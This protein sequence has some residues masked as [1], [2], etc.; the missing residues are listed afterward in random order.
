M[1]SFLNKV[2]YDYLQR[3]RSYGFLIALCASLAIAYSFVPEPNASYS[4]IRIGEFIGS[5]NSAWF[6]YVTAIMTSLFLSLIGFYLVNSGIKTD[7]TTR[8][9]QIMAATRVKNLNYLLAKTMSNFLVLLTITAVV[10]LMGILL[11][12][13]YR[14]SGFSFQIGHFIRPYLFITLPALFFV[15]ALAVC[16]EILLGRFTTVQNV[17]FFFLFCSLAI[18]TPKTDSRF[19]LDV[20]GSKI[21]TDQMETQVKALTGVSEEKGLTIGYVLGNLTKSKKFEFNGID[22][23]DTFV[24]SRL[25]WM[26]FGLL[27]VFACTPFFHRFDFRTPY[28]AT[29][30]KKTLVAQTIVQDIPLLDLPIGKTDYGILA[31]IKTELLLLW[32]SGKKWMWVI[33]FIGMGLLAFLPLNVAHKTVLPILWFLQVGRF[34]DL[35][36]KDLAHR[37]HYLSFSSHRP[38]RRLLLSQVLAASLGMLV[39]AMPM[40]VRYLI[41]GNGIAMAAT[42]LGGIGIVLFA[43]FLGVVTKG[44]KLFEVLFFLL[45]YANING[46]PFLDYFGGLHSTLPYVLHL[47]ILVLL[48]A[49][50]TLGSRMVQLNQ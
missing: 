38:I 43:A 26:A 30:S 2:K 36:S 22:F 42:T 9:G 37:V 3:T 15:S 25:G 34:S 19:T 11:F 23:P 21:V 14:D 29:R 35:T 4:T 10:F 49:I 6:G 48:L 39:L 13:L 28:K 1:K 33:N 18:W 8:V 41:A 46:I 31:L 5:Y 47:L 7:G 17:I 44:K 16:F 45:S 24:L 12:V 50:A 40:L 32:R 27:M 20:F